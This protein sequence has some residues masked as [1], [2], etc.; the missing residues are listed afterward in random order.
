MQQILF[1][2][3]AALT[4]TETRSCLHE[5]RNLKR[6]KNPGGLHLCRSR[7]EPDLEWSQRKTSCEG[8][9]LLSL[10]I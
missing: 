3:L 8:S 6:G 10:V 4:Q 7:V 9:E 2:C 5:K 1:G